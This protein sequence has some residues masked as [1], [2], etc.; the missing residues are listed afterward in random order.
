MFNDSL[1]INYASRNRIF[2]GDKQDRVS[3]LLTESPNNELSRITSSHC[4]ALTEPPINE[5]QLPVRVVNCD[6][7][8]LDV[9]ARTIIQHEQ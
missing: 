5:P 6:V 7:V 9:S 1:G 3:S 4:S 2:T 8:R